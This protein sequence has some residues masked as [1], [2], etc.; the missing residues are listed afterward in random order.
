MVV[1]SVVFQGLFTAA[2]TM[3]S[4]PRT[5]ETPRYCPPG[6]GDAARIRRFG[7]LVKVRAEDT[8]GH[9]SV[10]EHSLEEATLAMPMHKHAAETKTFY[11]L[12]GALT[13][14]LGS[15]TFIAMPG[16]SI[17]VP[18]GAM[19]TMWNETERRVRFLAVVAPG[20][21]ERYYAE[22]AGFVRP[23]GRP[24]IDRILEASTRY[25]VELDMLSL[26]DI[27]ERH[28]VQLA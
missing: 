20:G 12:E 17:V 19:H 13:V 27:L 25:G 18:A 8:D 10:L 22:V 28:H 24:D 15:N 26:L 14:K 2:P 21:L 5:S 9:Y 4:R 11:A 7:T 23:G 1:D 6:A 3:T 16:A